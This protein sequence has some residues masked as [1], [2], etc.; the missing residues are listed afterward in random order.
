MV[1]HRGLRDRLPVLPGVAVLDGDGGHV[2]GEGDGR[3]V[4]VQGAELDGLG[5]GGEEVAEAEGAVLGAGGGRGGQAGHVPV[6]DL[7]V[8]PG[9]RGGD[10]RQVDALRALDRVRADQGAL[11]PGAAQEHR[12]AADEEL[13]A[14]D[15][16]VAEVFGQRGLGGKEDADTPLEGPAGELLDDRF[17][18]RVVGRGD[19]QQHV[20]FVDDERDQRV[21][22]GE[23]GGAVAGLAVEHHRVGQAQGA[24]R[25]VQAVAAVGGQARSGDGAGLRGGQDHGDA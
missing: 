15:R 22:E 2:S 10:P 16:G 9:P 11:A 5:S 6:G 24:H 14:D 4:Q 17:G 7:G 18:L 3:H 25:L 23:G 13:G 8:L 19:R 21:G 12:A 20:C 1:D